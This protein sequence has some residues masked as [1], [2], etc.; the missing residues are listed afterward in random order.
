MFKSLI[1]KTIRFYLNSTHGF[2]ALKGILVNVENG[3]CIVDTYRGI[4]YINI[5]FIINMKEVSSEDETDE[6]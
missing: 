3:F 6:R 4:E 5:N 2:T 1:G